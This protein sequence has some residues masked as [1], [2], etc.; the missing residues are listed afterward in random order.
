[1]ADRA[2]RYVRRG[3]EGGPYACPCC[4]CLTLDER[5]MHG[6]CLVCFW[7]DDGTDD[8]S[9]DELSGPNGLTL[10]EARENFERFGACAELRSDWPEQFEELQC[11]LADGMPVDA[12]IALMRERGLGW[13]ESKKLLWHLVVPDVRAV[14]LLIEDS[15]TW[16][17]RRS[18][19][20]RCGRQGT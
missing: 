4:Q 12:A 15:A 9:A 2:S 1:M 10:T 11:R 5:G 14:R 20:A 7:Q 19:A 17:D 13:L 16:A 8:L 18:R 3:P 6:I